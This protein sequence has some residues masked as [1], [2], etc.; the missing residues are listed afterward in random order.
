[1][2]FRN[3]PLVICSN[4]H[5]LK[6]DFSKSIHIDIWITRPGAYAYKIEYEPLP[7]WDP[8]SEYPA[9]PIKKV[10]PCISW[11]TTRKL[12]KSITSPS[13]QLCASMER[14]CLWLDWLFNLSLVNGLDLSPN[15]PSS[16]KS[17]PAKVTT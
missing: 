12:P 9:E 5:R 15:G 16:S 11:L 2:R 4:C 3:I 14:T 13:S 17:S 6:P 7:P 8:L 1:M 10:S